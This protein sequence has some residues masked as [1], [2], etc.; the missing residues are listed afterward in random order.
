MTAST[1]Q[2]RCWFLAGI[3]KSVHFT[4]SLWSRYVWGQNVNAASSPAD[5]SGTPQITWCVMAFMIFVFFWVLIFKPVGL[6]QFRKKKM[7][8][9]KSA[10]QTQMDENTFTHLILLV[11]IVLRFCFSVDLCQSQHH[12]ERKVRCFQVKFL[13]KFLQDLVTI[14]LQCLICISCR[15]FVKTCN[16]NVLVLWR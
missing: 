8:R 11:C 10:R 4:G 16:S 3:L 2:D 6:P 5:Y 9:W 1:D 14:C 7:Q 13:A 12:F 15:L